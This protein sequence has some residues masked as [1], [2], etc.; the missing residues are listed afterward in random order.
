M[1]RPQAGQALGGEL[2]EDLLVLRAQ[3]LDLRDVGHL[4]QPRARCLDVVAQF[5]EAEAVGG[6]A[7]DDAEGV[8]E[9]VVEERARAR[10]AA[11]CARMS[12]MFLRTWY[13]MS[14]TCRGGV[15]PLQVDEDR[16]LR[17]RWCS[18][19][20]GRDGGSPA[21]CAR[22]AR[23]PAAASRPTV[24]PG[25]AAATTIVRMVKA[26]SSPRPR[27]LNDRRAR[28]HREDHQ[29]DDQRAL[30]SAP[31]P[32]GSG[33]SRLRVSSRRTFWPGRSACTPAV[34]TTSPGFR[35]RATCTVVGVR[36]RATSMLRSDDGARPWVDDP[37]RR[38]A[39][40]ADQ[41]RGRDLD[42]RR[43][44]ELACGP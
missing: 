21:A 31:I 3:H 35:P 5:A 29:E 10:P 30:A 16:R 17:R 14:G 8:A 7:V 19:A 38:L 32:T 13:Q 33:R 42:G 15:E 43:R 36:T 27:R 12:P 37:H 41:R 6:E 28:D 25:Q 18:C 39:V 40:G 11:A 34:T 26:G 9:V 1:F 20:G 24:A 2:D 23:S 4:Q 22:A 44:V